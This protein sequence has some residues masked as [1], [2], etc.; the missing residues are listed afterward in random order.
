MSA[1]ADTVSPPKLR[2]PWRWLLIAVLAYLVFLIATIPAVR[3]LPRLIPFGIQAVGASGTLWNGQVA[4]LN[5]RGI[6]LGATQWRLQP[7]R[8]VTGKLGASIHSKNDNGYIDADVVV[9]FSGAIQLRNVRALLPLNALY[10]LQLPGGGLNGWTGTLQAELDQVE[11]VKQWPIALVGRV[12]VRDLVG[13][14]REPV[15]LGSYRLTFTPSTDKNLQGV[16]SSEE[17]ALLD[18]VGSVRLSV[19]R[20]YVVDVQVAARPGA[21]A[22]IARVLEYLGVPDAQG[23]RPLSLAG[24]L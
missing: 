13:P 15:Q 14:P 9:G 1:T 7:W 19:D 6:S 18:A 22:N 12:D 5:A 23:R 17:G 16:L 11:L 20:S 24:E 3:M 2:F 10:G 21:P 4:A 8:L